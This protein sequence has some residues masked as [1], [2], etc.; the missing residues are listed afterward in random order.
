MK[1][2]PR[3]PKRDPADSPAGLVAAPLEAVE[4]RIGELLG[5]RERLLTEIGAYLLDS[6]G[7]RIRPMVVLLSY[8]AAGGQNFE[9]IVDAAAALELIHSASLLHDDIIDEA[10]LRRGRTSPLRKYGVASTLVAG[11]FLFS[12]AYQVCGRYDRVVI[13]WAALACVEL[14]EGEILQ[15]R[16]RRNPSVTVEDYFEI[17]ARKTASLFST[18][19]RTGAY[20]AGSGPSTVESFSRVGHH[21]GIAFQILD[22]VLDLESSEAELGKP[23]G[24]D[25]REGTPS[26]PIVLALREDEAVRNFF[27]EPSPAEDRLA[28]V[29]ERLRSSRALE[30]ARKMAS[31]EAAKAR[32]ILATLAANAYREQFFALVDQ[33][34]RR[35]S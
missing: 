29:L 23:V 17:V 1:A 13:E 19:A 35:R 24:L 31:E 10:E 5:S 16:F 21:V 18:G 8:G 9:E 6:G 11:D 28:A 20:L 30:T 4:R 14:T 32:R 2:L 34:E 22:D 12:R 27:L 7:K 33:L 25:L 15:A 3:S 26:L